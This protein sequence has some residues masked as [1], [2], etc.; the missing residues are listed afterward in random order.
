MRT[1]LVG[2]CLLSQLLLWI[3]WINTPDDKLHLV[4]CDV[5][6]GDGFLLQQGT[7]QVVIDGGPPSDGMLA[8]LKDHMPFWDTT[9]ELVVASH[10]DSDHIGGLIAVVE[11]YQVSNVLISQSTKETTVFEQFNQIVQKKS[12]QGLQIIRPRMGQSFDLGPGF[13][14]TVVHPNKPELDAPTSPINPSSSERVLQDSLNPKGYDSRVVPT[15]ENDAS[16]ILFIAYHEKSFL[17]TGD[18]GTEIES[19]LVRNQLI[20]EVDVLKTSHHGSKSGTS[21]ALLE[22][23]TPEIALISVGKNNPYGHPNQEVIQRLQ[24]SGT[25][26]L[27]TDLLGEVELVSDGTNIWI[28]H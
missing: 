21:Q 2:L 18:A 1:V 5:G 22:V 4:M 3:G 27:R 28:H 9:I 10:A 24:R 16:I 6:Q 23:I 25:Q 26:I 15:N 11:S 20:A 19:A 7:T 17:F 13:S 12:S 14:A 8:C